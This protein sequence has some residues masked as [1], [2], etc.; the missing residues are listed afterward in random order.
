MPS[1][2]A[3][4]THGKHTITFGG[5]FSYT[6]LNARDERTNKGM[7]GFTDFANFLRA[8]PSPIPPTDSSP[9]LSCRATPTAT[10]AP[11][12][13]AQYIQDKFQLR[14]NLSVSAG[15]RFDYHGGLT[16][17]TASSTIS[18]RQLYNYNAATDT[19]ISNGFIIAGNNPHFPTKG[20][21]DSTLTGRQWGFAPRIGVAWSPK[22]IQRQGCRARGWG[23][24]YDRG[25]LF[26]YFSP[27]FAAGVIAGGPFGVNQSPPWVNA[28]RLAVRIALLRHCSTLREPRGGRRSVRL[29]PAIRQI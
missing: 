3:I 14:S 1:A 5:S 23:M 2:N 25:E 28:A 12:K 6:Q 8:C 17:R 7:I 24:Y 19:I 16:K 13:M 9:P 4:W 22:E 27:G 20:V 15:L 21:S 26:T 29:P 10:T 18:I 11:T